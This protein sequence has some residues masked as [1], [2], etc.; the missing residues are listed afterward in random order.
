MRSIIT[1]II[2]L[3]FC[4]QCGR[5][6]AIVYEEEIRAEKNVQLATT[7]L[8][9]S[10]LFSWPKDLLILDT[11]LIVHDAYQQEACF[12][13]FRKSDGKFIKSFG[14]KGRGPGEF[15]DIGSVSRNY[16]RGTI[17]VYDP[18]CKKIVEFDPIH[19]LQD[20]K[21]Y[22][23]EYA[24]K[25]APNFIKQALPHKNAYVVKGNDDK[26]RYGI[27]NPSNQT[28]HAIYT[29]YPQ[30]ATEDEDNWALTDFGAKVRLSPDG[31]RM[32]VTTYIGG[33]LEL[34][35][36][37][38]EGFYLRT[39]RFFFEPRYDYAQGAKPRW[40]TT[41]FETVIGFQDMVLTNEAIY[42][43]VWGVNGAEMEGN[44]PR[45]FC[46]DFEG[47]PVISYEPDE[48]LDCVAV[49]DDGTIYGVGSDSEGEYGLC[50]YITVAKSHRIQSH[51]FKNE[52]R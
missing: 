28:F 14:R 20:R 2:I 16:D 49:D 18:N 50:K 9:D 17:T 46:F 25:N 8:N 37:D 32:A 11:L 35:D 48:S 1:F 24:V 19:V 30:L 22:F 47:N 43:L 10:F 36:M 52:K 23:E 3:E 13:I 5:Q 12:H 34:F 4:C 6:S 33:V 45:L 38:G 7:V 15:M 31:T 21:P 42:G 40:V 39:S 41:S 29:D 26:L 44:K 51:V 27:L